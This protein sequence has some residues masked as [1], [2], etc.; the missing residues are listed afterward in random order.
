MKV[1][2]VFEDQHYE[3]YDDDHISGVFVK[4]SATVHGVYFDR[5]G[6]NN[7]AHRLTRDL[8]NSCLNERD[9]Y[10]YVLEKTIKGNFLEHA[11]RE[12]IGQGHIKLIKE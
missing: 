12:M 7:K 10:V 11:V 6:A 3:Q 4:I 8:K 2:I 5:R 1:Y 9:G